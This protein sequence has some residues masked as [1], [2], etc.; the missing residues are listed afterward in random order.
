MKVNS[1]LTK[2][3]DKESNIMRMEI[4]SLKV[5]SKLTK[6]MDKES[7]IIRMEIRST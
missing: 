4:R 1:N 6:G 5:P 7:N 3:M 2:G